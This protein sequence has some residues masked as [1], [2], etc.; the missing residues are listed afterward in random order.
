MSLFLPPTFF[1]TYILILSLKMARLARIYSQSRLSFAEH[2]GN[3]FHRIRI[4]FLRIF[5]FSIFLTKNCLELN[6]LYYVPA[7]F[8]FVFFSF[9]FACC[10]R[11][12]IFFLLTRSLFSRIDIV[13]EQ[14]RCKF[15]YG[16]KELVKTSFLGIYFRD[17]N[18]HAASVL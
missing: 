17:V 3:L 1:Y 18:L 13:E 7:N 4:I 8:F 12:K 16:S 15:H 5:L 11:L 10:E 6:L 2:G 14:K 9:L